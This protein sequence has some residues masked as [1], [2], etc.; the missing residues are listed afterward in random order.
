MR[1]G[2][3][4][5][6]K[7]CVHRNGETMVNTTNTTDTTN[8]AGTSDTTSMAD[9]TTEMSTS[10][11][12]RKLGDLG[13]P[14]TGGRAVLRERLLKALG[15]KKSPPQTNEASGIP[16]GGDASMA[17]GDDLTKLPKE[18]LKSRLRE[19]GL[20]VSGTKA[21]LRERLRAA[22]QR[23][24]D[25]EDDTSDEEDDIGEDTDVRGD[26]DSIHGGSM[27]GARGGIVS[28]T[29]GTIDGGA[30]FTSDADS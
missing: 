28:A 2:Y 23:S 3:V 9:M 20:Q 25:D 8:M 19:L 14:T 22:L 1:C 17:D 11:L 10:E 18:T 26:A 30:R 15:L 24:E 6:E 29:R 5:R 16:G 12:A 27:E 4:L 21:V 13:L 7:A